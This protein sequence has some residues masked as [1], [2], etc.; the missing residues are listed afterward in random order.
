[1][2]PVTRTR[3][4]MTAPRMRGPTGQRPGQVAVSSNG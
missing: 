4:A 3:S 2:M 1:V